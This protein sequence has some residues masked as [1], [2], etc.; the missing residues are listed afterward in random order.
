[1]AKRFEMAVL[2][3]QRDNPRARRF[4][5][6]NGW[7]CGSGAEIVEASWAGPTMD[8]I[9]PLTEPLAKIEY[10]RTMR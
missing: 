1:L 7:T 4:Y 6:R 3:V 10:R 2:W 5:E 9:E 8:G